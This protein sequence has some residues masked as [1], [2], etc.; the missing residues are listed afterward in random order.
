MR[1]HNVKKASKGYAEMFLKKRNQK[2]FSLLEMVVTV[3]IGSVM[4]LGFGS[5]LSWTA[6]LQTQAVSKLNIENFKQQMMV[7]LADDTAWLNTVAG[8]GTN[9]M[10]CLVNVTD[11]TTNGL[12]FG[13][14]IEKRSFM[15][16]DKDNQVL[17]DSTVP[18]NGLTAK[19]T[20]C[21]AVS[22]PPGYDG[23]NGNDQCPYRYELHWSAVCS[24]T[25]PARP[26]T[27]PQVK[28]SAFLLHSPASGTQKTIMGERY[29]IRDFYAGPS[30]CFARTAIIPRSGTFTVPADYKYLVAEVWGGGGGGT[31]VEGLCTIS[32]GGNGGFSNFWTVTAAG[33][34]GGIASG[35]AGSTL[36]IFV[37]WCWG[38][39]RALVPYCPGSA[40]ISGG[41]GYPPT[42]YTDPTIPPEVRMCTDTAGLS[43]GG[44]SGKGGQACAQNGSASGGG[45]AGSCAAPPRQFVWPFNCFLLVLT[46]YITGGAGAGVTDAAFAPRD[47]LAG[48]YNRAVYVP[49]TLAPGTVVPVTVGVGGA[50]GAIGSVVGG[51]G[52]NGLVKIT[53]W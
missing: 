13:P 1:C 27:N 30:P 47:W 26:C 50:R 14:P 33:G 16:F 28:I 34:Q 49:S 38:A 53:W 52:G 4:T 41:D 48:R 36:D 35:I 22:A 19:G 17:F 45:G 5:L 44:G 12:P 43:P 31:A 40:T 11:C 18:S 24:G 21:N 8:N 20:P 51:S 37:A 25:D 10:A 32:Q 2:G 46:P 6:N 29:S 23:V 15:L 3:A 42:P 39:A 9:S 7:N